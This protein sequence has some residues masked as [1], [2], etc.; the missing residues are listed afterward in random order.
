[1]ALLHALAR[2][3]SVILLSVTLVIFTY[4]P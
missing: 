2:N 4:I 1:M 3:A